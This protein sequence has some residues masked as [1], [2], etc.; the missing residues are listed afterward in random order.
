MNRVKTLNNK[1][2]YSVN[3]RLQHSDIKGI[4]RVIEGSK[5]YLIKAHSITIPFFEDY[6]I[7]FNSKQQPFLVTPLPNRSFS[8]F[9]ERTPFYCEE[10]K[11]SELHSLLP[12]KQKNLVSRF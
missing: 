3:V 12:Y 6:R 7:D 11:L 10:F 1:I 2:A 4:I 8:D 5:K 9:L